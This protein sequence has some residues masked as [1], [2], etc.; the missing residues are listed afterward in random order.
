VNAIDFYGTANFLDGLCDAAFHGKNRQYTLGN[1]TTQRCM[2]VW[3]DGVPREGA[4]SYQ[5]TPWNRNSHSSTNHLT[6]YCLT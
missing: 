6:T 2:G 5:Q 1:T 4:E 3:S